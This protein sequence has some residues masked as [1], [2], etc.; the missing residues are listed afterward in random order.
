MFQNVKFENTS[1]IIPHVLFGFLLVL[2]ALPFIQSKTDFFDIEP[3]KGDVKTPESD[4]LSIQKWFS[5]DYQVKTEKYLNESFGF[6]NTCIRINNQLAFDLDKKALANGVII[7]KDNYI[8]EYNYIRAYYGED[9]IGYDSINDRMQMLKYIQDTLKSL[10]KNLILV[11]A[12]GK[13]SFYP[14]YIPDRFKQKR[15]TTNYETYLDLA[16]KL[17]ITHIDF[18]KY[19]LQK[20]YTS[21]YPLYPQYGIHWSRYGMALATDSLITFIEDLRNIDL[22]GI[23][24]SE[25]ELD[26]PD[27]A[28]Y[29]IAS[30]MNIYFRLK[31]FEMGYPKI[32]FESDSGKAS[33]SILAIGDSFYFGIYGTATLKVFSN[34]HYWY[35]NKQIYPESYQKTITTDQLNLKEEIAKYDIIILMATESTLPKLGWGFIENTYT[36]FKK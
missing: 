31:S 20:K 28:D 18:K 2:L 30:G 7:G 29:D 15:N 16:Q 35:Y 27:D 21:P 8:Y 19:F 11:F 1:S 3:L 13:G 32:Q 34:S 9:Y 24:W 26:Q 6:R 17:N 36:A 25:V 10:N 5:G 12:P 4:T 14:E 33:P 22:R 23:Y